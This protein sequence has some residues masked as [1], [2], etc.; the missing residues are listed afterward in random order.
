MRTVLIILAII[1]VVFAV[2][3]GYDYSKK[4]KKA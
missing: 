4:M 1:G 3:Y 2:K